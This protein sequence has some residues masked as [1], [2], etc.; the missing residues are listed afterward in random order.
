MDGISFTVHP[1][2]PRAVGSGTGGHD[3]P[4]RTPAKVN[5]VSL[6]RTP[7]SRLGSRGAASP[8]ACLTPAGSHRSRTRRT[9]PPAA[10]PSATALPRVWRRH[11]RRSTQTV[12]ELRRTERHGGRPPAGALPSGNAS[13]W[14]RLPALG[15]PAGGLAT[16]RRPPQQEAK[17]MHAARWC[18]GWGSIIFQAASAKAE[19]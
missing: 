12:C 3:A 17:L 18:W 13:G 15:S 1:A 4:I 16:C 2:Q 8:A 11:R 9:L 19:S 5:G 7:S 10:S 14:S 6:P